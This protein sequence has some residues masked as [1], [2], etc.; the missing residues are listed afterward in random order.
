MVDWLNF[1]KPTRYGS[2]KDAPSFPDGTKKVGNCDEA[3]GDWPK[4]MTGYIV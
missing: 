3:S 2:R 1:Q 4:E